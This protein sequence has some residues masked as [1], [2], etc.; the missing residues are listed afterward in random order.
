MFVS[1]NKEIFYESHI[2]ENSFV[3]E[4][5]SSLRKNHC[6]LKITLQFAIRELQMFYYLW[7]FKTRFHHEET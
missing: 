6:F 5:L 1:K 3:D 2:K 4:R 7:L